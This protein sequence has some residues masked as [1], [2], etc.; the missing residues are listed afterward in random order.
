MPGIFS[1]KIG[2]ENQAVGLMHSPPSPAAPY[3]CSSCYF[4][5]KLKCLHL[6]SS[7][8]CPLQNSVA[9]NLEH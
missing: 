6:L 9:E 8:H 2:K 4:V 5:R 1:R 3:E 7:Q